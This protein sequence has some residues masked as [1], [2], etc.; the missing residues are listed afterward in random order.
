MDPLRISELLAE[1]L[2]APAAEPG[3]LSPRQLDQISMYVDLLLRWNAR[4]NLTAIRAPEE[5]VTRHFGESLFA[6]RH[7]FPRNSQPPASGETRSQ[8]EPG[9]K[10]HKSANLIDVGSG[11]G[12]PGVPI[13]IWSPPT[14]VTLIESNQKKATFLRETIRTLTL[15]NINVFSG[16][17]EDYPGASASA[18]TLRAVENFHKVLPI[19]ARLLAPGGTLAL[20]IGRSQFDRAQLSLPKAT[21]SAPVAVPLSKD[22]V[23]ACATVDTPEDAG[24]GSAE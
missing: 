20:L 15:T 18:V 9:L 23:L 6:A 13:N 2:T 1:F 19:A 14:A 21:W 24:G 17:A 22:R 16:R 7:L 4:M 12:F 10:S 11:A 5:V 3:A 8:T